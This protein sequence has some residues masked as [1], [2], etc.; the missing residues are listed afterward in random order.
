MSLQ[1]HLDYLI[2]TNAPPQD[3]VEAQEWYESR[4]DFVQQ[5]IDAYPPYWLYRHTPT[6]HI[7]CVYSYEEADGKC[8]TCSTLVLRKYNPFILIERRVIGVPFEHLEKWKES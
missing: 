7:V 1:Q 3:R 2:R 6:G 5:R 4:P 8:T